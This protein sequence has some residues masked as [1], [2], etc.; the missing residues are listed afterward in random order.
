M[1]FRALGTALA[2]L[3]L[4]VAPAAADT[5]TSHGL[6]AFGDLKYP[7]DFEHFDYVNPDAPKGGSM[8]LMHNLLPGTFDTLNAFILEGDEPQGMKNAEPRSLVYDSLMTRA[9]DEPDAVYGLVAESAELPE[10]RSWVIFNLR[11]EARWHDGSPITADDVAWTFAALKEQGDPYYAV[12][13][14]DVEKAEALNPQQVKFTFNPDGPVRDLPM[15]VAGLPI[16]SKAYYEQHDFTTVS[17]DPP[18]ASGPYK[19]GKVQPG[20]TITYERVKDY[21]AK[22]LPVSVGRFNFDEIRFEY[23]KDRSIGMEAFLAGTYDLREEFT[24]KTWATGYTGPAVEAGWI[25]RDTLPDHRPSG[26]QAFF[27]NLRRDKFKDPLVRK[28]LDYAF[29]FEW[30]DKVLFFGAYDR[31]SSM[32]ENSTLEATGLPGEAELALLKPFE[33]DLPPAVFGPA[34]MPP[35]TDGSGSNR[36]NLRQAALFLRQAGLTVKDG[37]MHLPDGSPFEIEFLIFEPGF[38]RIIEP[39]TESLKRLGIQAAIRQVDPAQYE[40]RLKDFD[41]DMTT[42]R[43]TMPLTPGVEQRS[44]WSS[45]QADVVGSRNIGGVKNPAVDSLIQTIV[46]AKTRES[47]V[48]A[49]HALDRVLMHS[50]NVVPQWYKGSYTVGWWDR[51]GRPEAPPPFARGIMDLWWYDSQK[52]GA[53]DRARSGN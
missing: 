44:F 51:F 8:A 19:V 34:Y 37:V 38:I 31:V 53:I 29:D 1:I 23:F 49:V 36:G 41:F 4:V 3:M 45:A 47:L 42:R 28:A 11:K 22:D 35:S 52:S 6:S 12:L 13:L 25:V 24:S 21:W 39:Y 5:T 10:D 40:R 18:L 46:G 2:V 15:I 30:T 26:A 20:R 32:F 16:L 17:L 7:A 9:W 14:R 48:T 50:H 27:L 33:K 43:L